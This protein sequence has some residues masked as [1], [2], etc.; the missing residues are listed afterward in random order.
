MKFSKTLLKVFFFL[1]CTQSIRGQAPNFFTPVISNLNEEKQYVKAEYTLDLKNLRDILHSAES[2]KKSKASSVL[3][4]F[5]VGPNTFESFKVFKSTV[6]HPDLEAKFPLIRTYIGYGVQDPRKRVRFSISHKNIHATIEIPDEDTWYLNPEG[7]AYQLYRRGEY[8]QQTSKNREIFSCGVDGAEDVSIKLPEAFT[9]AD[10]KS[11]GS[12]CRLRTYRLAIATTGE[13]TDYH[14]GTVE[15]A[16]AEVVTSMVR[17][18]GIYEDDF[19]VTMQ[20]VANNDEVIFTN[21]STDPFTN[22]DPGAMLGEN[23]TALNNIIGSENFDIGHVYGVGGGGLATLRCPCGNAKARAMTGLGNPINDPFY[24]DYVSHEMGHQF[25][26]NHTQNNNCNRSGNTAWEPGSASTIMGYAG[27]CSPNVQ[28]NSD[29]H[30]HGGSIG[31]VLSFIQNG[32]GANCGTNE[33]ISNDAPI[34]SLA[35]NFYTLPVATPFVLTAEAEDPNEEDVLTYCWEQMDQA[36]ATMPPS[37][38]STVG[39]AFRSISPTTSGSR[40]FPNLNDLVNNVGPTWE[41]LPFFSRD[42]SFRLT[43]RDNHFMGGCQQ[44]TEMLLTFD[45]SAGP[46]L[47]EIPNTNVSWTAG[48]TQTI[49]WNVANTDQFPVSSPNVDVF[50]STD[51]GFTYPNL[52]AENI[53]NNGSTTINVPAVF[54]DSCRIMVKGANHVFFDISDENFSISSPFSLSVDQPS[55]TIC[56]GDQVNYTLQVELSDSFDGTIDFSLESVPLGGFYE[57]TPSSVNESGSVNLLLTNIAPNDYNFTIVAE[58]SELTINE[59]IQLNVIP[60]I[61]DNIDQQSPENYSKNISNNPVLEWTQIDN[62]LEYIIELDKTPAFNSPNYQSYTSNTNTIQL[63]G[64]DIASVYYWKVSAS[65]D[66]AMSISPIHFSFQT[67]D[68]SCD[69]FAAEDLPIPISNEAEGSY[70]SS[71]DIN[72]SFAISEVSVSMEIEHSW[73]GDID[74]FLTNESTGQRIELFNRLGYDGSGFGCD[75]SNLL[76]RFSDFAENTAEDLEGTCNGG[77]FAAEGDYQSIDPLNQLIGQMPNNGTWVLEIN[78]YYNGDGGQLLSWSMDICGETTIS[79]EIDIEQNLLLVNLGETRA[80]SNGFLSTNDANP[81]Q[82]IYTLTSLPF[83]GSLFLEVGA[84]SNELAIGDQFTQADIDNLRL[85]Y[86]QDG[87]EQTMDSF[88]YDLL[89]SGN[90]WLPNQLFDIQIITEGLLV[91]AST[92]QFIDCPGDETGSISITAAGGLEPYEYNL[93]NGPYQD[94]NLFEGLAAGTYTPGVRDE[95]GNV[96]AGNPITLNDPAPIMI[97]LS[98]SFFSITANAT[99]GTGSL[100]YSINGSDYQSSNTFENLEN[101][102]Y[103]IFVKDENDCVSSAMISISVPLLDATVLPTHPLCTGDNNANLEVFA[104]GGVPPYEYS[105]DGMDYQSSAVFENLSSGAFMVYIKDDA[106]QVFVVENTELIDPEPLEINVT[107]DGY[108]INIDANGGTGNYSYS[109]DG[110]SNFSDNSSFVNLPNDTY[111]IVVIDE[112]DCTTT[113]QTTINVQILSISVNEA[114][115]VLACYNDM[116]A[117]IVVDVT[118]GLAP[119]SYSLDNVNFQMSNVF[120]NL[121][122]GSYSIYAQDAVQTAIID[123]FI[124]DNPTEISFTASTFNNEITVMAEGGTGVYTYSLDGMNFQDSNILQAGNNGSYQVYVQDSNGC[125]VSS[126][127]NVSAIENVDYLKQ[128]ILCHGVYD[129]ALIEVANIDGGFPNYEYSLDGVNYQMSNI[130]AINGPGTYSLYVRDANNQTFQIDNINFEEPPLLSLDYTIEENTINLE[131]DGGTGEY[132][133]SI[134]G[135]NF[136]ESPIFEDLSFDT[137]EA[138]VMDENG[139]ET[140]INIVLSSVGQEGF[141]LD[142]VISPNPG[143]GRYTI[144]ISDSK[145]LNYK[146]ELYNIGGQLLLE[147]HINSATHKEYKL[148]VSDA[149]A[150]LYFFVVSNPE[151]KKNTYRVIKE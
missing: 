89:G 88:K 105:L 62:A 37:P 140:T 24:V 72:E 26:G 84:N 93:N 7:Q 116:D 85:S 94:S 130:L 51:G 73:V 110:G 118:G 27:I 141:D 146:L 102:D 137:Y 22:G 82:A 78:D 107:S 92:N 50:L 20:L 40:Y 148:D 64:L 6:M 60:A 54:S 47:V 129:D 135:I 29:D 96:M 120:E 55:Q 87:S 77:D 16:L 67:A 21:A 43:V 98:T 28:N 36:V 45:E 5:P 117:T 46:F 41:V 44:N 134:D 143:D 115:Q 128:D 133:Y 104:S 139:C 32:G 106:D 145:K 39:P 2:Y 114:S 33:D 91:T 14:G 95:A 63:N 121:A 48:E 136:Q 100:M 86:T 18:N 151:G 12:D 122:A 83:A 30:F 19:G 90:A 142:L 57:F 52:L 8:K 59:V 10:T 97:N 42:M 113:S 101:G 53:P 76:L 58:N 138:I 124:I 127:I 108:T 80:I 68:S 61:L 25:G 119:I 144:S 4:S 15:D 56:V 132:S 34:I 1:A 69:A 109:I 17:V 71:I 125:L 149:N 13:Y 9:S 49:Q 35:S 131:A 103:T 150:G 79:Q 65:N 126:T 81:T 70:L 66:C 112:N 3:L 74:A 99:G 111:A 75:Q 123:N 38:T 23:Q 147:D 11:Q 31:E